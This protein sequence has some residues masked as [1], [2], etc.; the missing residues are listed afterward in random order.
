MVSL[1]M[2][3]SLSSSAA[4][5][6]AGAAAAAASGAAPA[7]LAALDTTIGPKTRLIPG[8]VL[9]RSTAKK[10]PQAFARELGA[11]LGRPLT[12]KKAVVL[13]W[14][15]LEDPTASSE[16]LTLQLVDDI[17]RIGGV[18]DTAAVWVWRKFFAPNDPFIS[19]MWPL[20]AI[21]APAAWNI[22]RGSTS[23]RVGVVDTGTVFSHEDFVGK[24]GP[25]FDF[26]SDPQGGG[27]GNGR[28]ADATD[29]GDNCQGEGNSFHGTHVAGTILA[30]HNNGIG[31]AGLNGNAKLV[32]GRSLGRC[33]GTN[34][35]INEAVAWMGGFQV[36]G[37]TPLSAADRPRVVN[38]SLGGSGQPC[39]NFTNSVWE[40]VTG[41]GVIVVVASGNDGNNVAVA[42]PANC[43]DSVAVAAFDITRGGAPGLSN[44]AN[45]GPEISIV[46]PGGN[47]DFGLEGGV[48]SS[49]D[50]SIS[51]FRDGSPYAFY[52]GTSMAAPHVA[53]VI[54]LMLDVN[55]ALDRDGVVAILQAQSGSCTS[56]QGKPALR[57]DL[58]V[59]AAAG[60]AVTTSPG[61]TCAGT[62]FCS[63]GQQCVRAGT[64]DTCLLVCSNNGGCAAGVACTVV[65]DAGFS[66]CFGTA[67]EGEGEGEG[68]GEDEPG[69]C[70]ERR[71]NMD[72]K[73]GAGCV[74]RECVKGAD[75][76]IGNR[77]LC[78]FDRDCSSGICDLGVCTITCDGTRCADGYS[79]LN[80]DDGGV[81]GGLCVADSCVDD[82]DICGDGFDCSYSSAKRYVCA[83]GSS[84]YAGLCGA[85]PGA[86]APLAVLA[87]A[88]LRRR[89]R[90]HR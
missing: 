30:N 11:A 68:E 79:C 69:E 82:R 33:G 12:F 4:P 66:V 46:A 39:D 21:G 18:K 49:V 90:R 67:A 73:V 51:Q 29:V 89:R 77:G 64:V 54:S 48:L 14:V 76:D 47:V 19:L 22:T 42:S 37:V 41:Q 63:S 74:D 88:L 58:A 84:N 44:Y 31:I 36:D 13:G 83:A 62:G 15:Q 10:D 80:E 55:G 60:T 52:P 1:V 70:D 59:A 6:V 50:R 86:T 7:V 45:F 81:P 8:Q 16:A 56:C 24:R 2:V 75:G 85:S 27:D 72:C 87:L 61:D 71:G 28:D 53:G 78:E 25:E 65:P 38:L 26:I 20:D 23:N 34:V 32:T 9:V 57:A 3:T 17:A 35:D 5:S 40:A 43:K